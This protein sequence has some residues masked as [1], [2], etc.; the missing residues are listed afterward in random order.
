VSKVIAS[1]GT[2]P[3]ERLLRLARR[4]VAPYARRHGY[5]LALHT[6][7][8]E[9]T[10]PVPWS[11]VLI[12]RDLVEHHE[13]VVW[14]DADLVV[15]DGRADIAAELPADR[16]LGLVEH[17]IGAAR[18]P[19]SGVMVLRGGERSAAFL[20]AVWALDEYTNHQWWE[21]AAICHLLGYT[22]D[23]P[24]SVGQTE[25]R[26]G[27]AFLSPRWNWIKDARV[28]RARIRHFPGFAPR[29]RLGLMALA[30]AEAKLRS[31]LGR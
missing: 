1:L 27:A 31:V 2:G 9:T 12:L 5:E 14:L 24:R 30:T 20:D 28:R 8:V 15:V 7:P 17:R 6:V 21:N 10:R 16:F 3:Q 23:P 4:T 22:L 19:N 13:T 29:T 11:K 26:T 18:F 25:W